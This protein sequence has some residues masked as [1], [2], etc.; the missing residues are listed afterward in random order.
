[1]NDF[2]KVAEFVR[3][4]GLT[5]SKKESKGTAGGFD[6]YVN[7]VFYKNVY[8]IHRVQVKGFDVKA[9]DPVAL[10]KELKVGL[11]RLQTIEVMDKESLIKYL[12]TNHTKEGKS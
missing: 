10:L 3:V 11:G 9:F 2:R 1:M 4:N 8:E 7:I 12:L 5:V 6:D